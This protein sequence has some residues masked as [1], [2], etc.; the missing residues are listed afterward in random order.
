MFQETLQDLV[1]RAGARCSMIVG[2]DGILVETDRKD[3][4][5]EAEAL[6]AEYATCL[7]GV[8]KAA[9]NTEMGR[10]LQ[11]LF[12]TD[13]GKVLVQILNQDYFLA[14]L[15]NSDSYP[16]KAV[17]ECARVTESLQKELSA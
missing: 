10:V 4:R 14:V 15:L 6:A 13:K 2:T 9:R 12:A 11:L 1:A 3:F 16:G 7:R 5:A 17:F 8:A